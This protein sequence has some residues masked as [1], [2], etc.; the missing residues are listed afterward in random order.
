MQIIHQLRKHGLLLFLSLILVW[1][2]WYSI[3]SYVENKEQEALLEAA[4]LEKERAR[5]SRISKMDQLALVD[6]N[7]SLSLGDLILENPTNAYE[8]SLAEKSYEK[9]L[10][11]ALFRYV[12]DEN[13][14]DLK[15]LFRNAGKNTVTAFGLPLWRRIGK[16][17]SKTNGQPPL[18][19]QNGELRNL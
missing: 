4:E 14:D 17:I 3:E 18:R 11:A 10:R 7:A 19:V 6:L 2:S 13:Y 8:A 15:T 1:L 12:E 5:T 16:L 9:I